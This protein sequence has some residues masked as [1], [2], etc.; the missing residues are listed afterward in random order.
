MTVTAEQI[1]QMQP[2]QR[3][4]CTVSTQPKAEGA[5]KTIERLMRRDPAHAKGLRRAQKLRGKRLNVYI[6]GNRRWVAREK[7]ARVVRALDGRTWEMDLN[8]AIAADLKSVAA[9]LSIENA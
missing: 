2:G 1:D 6:R 4:R 7:A 9:H 8:P 3:I 5:R